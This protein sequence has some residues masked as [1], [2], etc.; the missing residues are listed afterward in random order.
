M[1]ER[2][3]A[4]LYNLLLGY[5]PQSPRALAEDLAGQGV[6][7]PASLTDS[8][9]KDVVGLCSCWEGDILETGPEQV[10]PLLERIAKG[11]E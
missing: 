8:E 11:A 3:V 1:N 2:N 4:A 7:V 6:L 9:R 5:N 10:A